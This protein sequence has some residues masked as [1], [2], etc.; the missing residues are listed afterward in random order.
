MT[1]FQISDLKIY[2]PKELLKDVSGCK[3]NRVIIMA[4][5]NYGKM[6]V[7]AAEDRYQ[8]LK[9]VVI[10]TSN[11]EYHPNSS[12]DRI[13]RLLLKSLYRNVC[14]IDF[15]TVS[16]DLMKSKDRGGSFLW[17]TTKYF[18][19]LKSSPANIFQRF[20]KKKNPQNFL[21]LF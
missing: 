3:A 4:D 13:T 19:P 16:T 20:F 21:K 17:N 18:F 15:Q 2:L 10:F 14:L 1:F 7:D 8:N 5:Q 12:K 11:N 9:N 6:L